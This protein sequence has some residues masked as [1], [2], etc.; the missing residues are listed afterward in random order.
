MKVLIMVILF[1]VVIA[2]EVNFIDYATRI[3]EAPL[4]AKVTIDPKR[5][6]IDPL[7]G[8]VGIGTTENTAVLRDSHKVSGE[9]KTIRI[10]PT[11]EPGNNKF[12]IPGLNAKRI[13]IDPLT[14][15]LGIGTIP[16]ATTEKLKLTHLGDVWVE[17][18]AVRNIYITI[19]GKP[20]MTIRQE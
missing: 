17:L 8:D 18:S 16:P 20:Y 7:T 14:G 4:N 9:E 10:I 2:M 15:D 11:Q 19:D 6:R 13:R 5:I 3:T 1:I 12:T